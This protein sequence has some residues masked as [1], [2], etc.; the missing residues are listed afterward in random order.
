MK[1]K[2]LTM[3]KLTAFALCLTMLISNQSFM[4]LIHAEEATADKTQGTD[5]EKNSTNSDKNTTDQTV[6]NQTDDQ[7]KQE[8]KTIVQGNEDKNKT[9]DLSTKKDEPVT[10]EKQELETKANSGTVDKTG[11]TV[12]AQEPT[13]ATTKAVVNDGLK[14]KNINP[15]V[16][17]NPLNTNGILRATPGENE[18]AMSDAMIT[19]LGKIEAGNFAG[20][21]VVEQTWLNYLLEQWS[22][23]VGFSV[24]TTDGKTICSGNVKFNWYE[25]K[26]IYKEW[27]F[28]GNVYDLYDG[29]PKEN[30]MAK[31]KLVD[32]V[33]LVYSGEQLHYAIRNANSASIVRLAANIDLNGK[34]VSWIAIA[35][36]SNITIDG[37]GHTIYNLGCKDSNFISKLNNCIVKDLTFSY[38]NIVDTRQKASHSGIFGTVTGTNADIKLNNFNNVTV[39][40][41]MFY[42]GNR[43]T[44]SGSQNYLSPLG[45]TEHIN[46]NNCYSIN[47]NLFGAPGTHVGGGFARANDIYISNSFSI[48]SNIIA[49]GEHSGGF[50]SCTD[51]TA[52][53]THYHTDIQTKVSNCFTNNTV[54]GNKST[55][56]FIGG[57]N[58]FYVSDKISFVN[59]Y[60]SGSIEGKDS[61]GGF[62]ASVSATYSETGLNTSV[63]F[64]NCYSTSI[65]GMQEGGSNLG[66]FIGN[67][68]N[69]YTN[70]NFENCYAA[71]E[72]GGIDTDISENRGNFKTVGGFAGVK[73]TERA[74]NYI[75]CYY[76]KQTTGMHEWETGTKRDSSFNLETEVTED[77][78]VD[79]ISELRGVLTSDSDKSG[80]GLA[81]IPT[82][83]NEKSGFNG[84]S[85]TDSGTLKDP[86]W[87]FD[88][89]NTDKLLHNC[90]YPQLRV[91][92]NPTAEVWGSDTIKNLVAAFSYASVA[93]VH[94][95]V[96]DLGVDKKVLSTKVYDTVRE[97]TTRFTLT[98][99]VDTE[100]SGVATTIEWKKDIGPNAKAGAV[101]DT[102]VNLYGTDVSVIKNFDK[103]YNTKYKREYMT[104]DKFAPGIQWVTVNV[105]VGDQTGSRKIRII[106][107]LNVTPG[108]D[109]LNLH[110][111][112]DKYNHATSVRFSFSTGARLAASGLKDITRA[113]YPDSDNLDE[114]TGLYGAGD[115]RNDIIN[116]YKNAVV[117]EQKQLAPMNSF[118]NQNDDYAVDSAYI[119]SSSIKTDLKYIEG[120][121][122]T[123]VKV[124]L[125]KII[126]VDNIDGSTSTGKLNIDTK[127]DL[128]RS[129][130]QSATLWKEKL[131]GKKD[132]STTDIGDYIIE[133]ICTL[134]D[135]RYLKDSKMISIHPETYDVS[136]QVANYVDETFST[137]KLTLDDKAFALTAAEYKLDEFA[138]TNLFNDKPSPSSN[139]KIPGGL[140]ENTPAFMAAKKVNQDYDVKGIKLEINTLG[141]VQ[142]KVFKDFQAEQNSSVLNF[143][144]NFYYN[145]HEMNGDYY[146][147]IKKI[148]KP[149]TVKYDSVNKVYYTIFDYENPEENKEVNANLNDISANVKATIFVKNNNI[150]TGTLKVLKKTIDDIGNEIFTDDKFSVQVSDVTT[151]FKIGFLL[152]ARKEAIYSLQAGEYKISEIVPMNYSCES[153]SVGGTDIKDTGTFTITKDA[154]TD[155]VITNK[156]TSDTGGTGNVTNTLNVS[157]SE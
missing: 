120:T 54:Y 21:I 116:T 38:A 126:G 63:N 17:A 33:Y 86:N 123:Y 132:F 1:T 66:G 151:G 135:G 69:E 108:E 64:E 106:P 10:N 23:L 76:D 30:Y 26:D 29:E 109:K 145:S 133:Y 53:G 85:T 73:K 131:N 6:N 128:L 37:D 35:S 122:E 42:S 36:Q 89:G 156:K 55:G 144:Y 18:K 146:V 102:K 39:K 61:L 50:I 154:T 104:A 83:L 47:N 28:L 14:S 4:N 8:D 138:S 98:S 80:N 56:V 31:P 143:I 27:K 25:G 111:N 99:Y 121:T 149:Y 94:E 148:T 93:T 19:S 87:I 97:L 71:G 113:L 57:I 40:N 100:L 124:H 105:K 16:Q 155:I 112:K 22:S 114:D 136:L 152:P 43:D 3:K 140:T 74:V 44:S 12:V 2:K 157:Q 62:A 11:N 130:D 117:N 75:K 95:Q 118:K 81:S 110:A 119:T 20:G 51:I 79:N 134:P 90:M 48:D 41:S 72:V 77:P 101:A 92:Y 96:W 60:S 15:I 24:S 142:S 52:S 127:N 58:V 115:T 125:Y 46:A 153:I 32:G 68:N 91:F 67:V 49:T 88:G 45:H 147:S 65:V 137:D 139:F 59:C 13:K 107:T 141:G 7:Q 34:N 78:G 82:T 9:T 70:V 129:G 84:F 103:S 150:K 5:N